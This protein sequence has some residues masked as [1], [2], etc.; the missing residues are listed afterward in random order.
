M[1]TK[2]KKLLLCPEC[3]SDE[4]LVRSEQAFLVNTGEYYCESV[5]IFDSDAKVNCLKCSW[6]GRRD[7]LQGWKEDEN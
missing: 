5:K 3:D 1:K 6:R 2:Q 4:V 7:Q